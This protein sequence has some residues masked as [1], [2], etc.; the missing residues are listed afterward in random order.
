[1]RSIQPLTLPTLTRHQSPAQER[2]SPV[3]SGSSL[4]T[5]SAEFAGVLCTLAGLAATMKE[6]CFNDLGMQQ[7]EATYDSYRKYMV[8]TS[9][10]LGSTR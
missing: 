3:T 4:A 7:G 8:E 1:V 10:S 2:I 6:R 5:T 9:E